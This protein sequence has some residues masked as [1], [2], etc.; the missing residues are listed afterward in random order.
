M[1]DDK[2]ACAY[3]GR[4]YKHKHKRMPNTPSNYSAR[5]DY[6][7]DVAENLLPIFFPNGAQ[8]GK[9]SDKG[10]EIPIY[11]RISGPH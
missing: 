10:M 7:D 8:C 2:A 3:E 6:K 9:A 11:H 4:R 1:N 5:F